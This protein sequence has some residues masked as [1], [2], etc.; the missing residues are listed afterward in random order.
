M[1][2]NAYDEKQ[3][4][5]L[6]YLIYILLSVLTVIASWHTVK[7]T[8]LPDTFVR[9]ERYNADQSRVEKSLDAINQK[10]DNNW[11]ELSRKLDRLIQKSN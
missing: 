4:Q 3:V 11:V 7:I 6:T 2:N 1:A 9:L 10:M 8:S 5:W